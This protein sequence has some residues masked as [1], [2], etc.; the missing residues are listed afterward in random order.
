MCQVRV[1]GIQ[2]EVMLYELQAA[3]VSKDWQEL[4]EQY[5]RSLEF[6]EAGKLDEAH[7]LLESLV[8]D[9]R[10]ADDKSAHVLLNNIAAAQNRPVSER[11]PIVELSSK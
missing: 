6:Y 10:F 1:V 3:P 8:G 11:S 9:A 7:E 5:R 2:G 4:R